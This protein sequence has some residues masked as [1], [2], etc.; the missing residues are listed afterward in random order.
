MTI[1]IDVKVIIL[2]FIIPTLALVNTASAGIT[3]FDAEAVYEA[4]LSSVNVP[5]SP[6]PIEKIFTFNEDALLKHALISVSIPTMPIPI[7]E[8]FT[9]NR[10]A[11][12]NTH[13]Y[14]VS[15]PT[16]PTPIK[17]IFSHLEE[18]KTYE[19]LIFPTELINDTTSPLITNVT[20]TNITN[21]SATI[22]WTTDEIA[23]SV[24]NYGIDSEIYTEIESD[25]LFVLNHTI[26]LIQ[27]SQGTNYYFD[28]NS[29]DRSGNT[30]ESSE[31]KFS[32]TGMTN[33][34]LNA[35]GQAKHGKVL[36]WK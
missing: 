18:A 12:F 23:D 11:S 17:N 6:K 4:N 26:G 32:T 27:L 30:A 7:K 10:D 29:T 3:V 34:P 22:T 20:V 9:F 15:I 21:N 36:S 31:Y 33:Q 28:V 13:L 14:A 16:S 5:T 35:N 2:F 1:T 8:I 19:A 24:V 25:S